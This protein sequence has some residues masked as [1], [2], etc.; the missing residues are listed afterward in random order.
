MRMFIYLFI[1]GM[2]S[3]PIFAQLPVTTAPDQPVLTGYSA[4]GFKTGS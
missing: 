1:L 4:S 3:A 2:L